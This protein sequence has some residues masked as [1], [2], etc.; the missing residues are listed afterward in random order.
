MAY[1]DE[2]GK[3]TDSS[4]YNYYAIYAIDKKAFKAQMD[5]AMER[6]E[7]TTTESEKLKQIIGQNLEK[8]MN[9]AEAEVID[10]S[11]DNE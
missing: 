1:L 5:A 4:Y 7:E 3:V 6:V 2:E 9:F 11:E 10:N 8:S